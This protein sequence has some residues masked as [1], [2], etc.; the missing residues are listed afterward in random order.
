MDLMVAK[1]NTFLR[2]FLNQWFWTR[3][4]KHILNTLT[5][6]DNLYIFAKQLYQKFNRHSNGTLVFKRFYV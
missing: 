5:A 6:F 2:I 4:Y 1:T 3:Q